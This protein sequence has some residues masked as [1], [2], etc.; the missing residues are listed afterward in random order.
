MCKKI[1]LLVMLLITVS[2]AHAESGYKTVIYKNYVSNAVHEWKKVIDKMSVSGTLANPEKLE[3]LNYHY[4][5]I[6]WCMMNNH[7]DEAEKYLQSAEK[8]A[9]DLAADK[10]ELSQVMAYKS[11]LTGFEM[12]LAFYKAPFLVLD[13]I[14]YA[15]K[16]IK[17]DKNNYLGY[18]QMGYID[19]FL[20][21]ILGGSKKEAIGYYMIAEKLLYKQLEGG[22]LKDWNYI[23][24][25]VT[26]EQAYEQLG[27]TA[28]AK[29]YREKVMHIEPKYMWIKN[30]LF[31]NI[32]KRTK[33]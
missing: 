32:D 6:G 7:D 15:K 13:C 4:G 8:L 27:Q 14:D 22:N 9:D 10:Y 29:V 23:N 5:F 33:S 12:G 24:I 3:L 11:A 28:K 1:I 18:L 31:N 25:L 19:F 20:P 17:L 16:S 21:A 26:I 2:I 30:E